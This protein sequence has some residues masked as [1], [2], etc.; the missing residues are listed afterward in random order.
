MGSGT[1]GAR[2]WVGLA[3]ALTLGLSAC[4]GGDEG[5]SEKLDLDSASASPSESPDKPDGPAA[6]PTSFPDIGLEI[7][8]LPKNPKGTK[9]ELLTTWAT[10]EHGHQAMTRSLR[11]NKMLSAT[12]AAQARELMRSQANGLKGSNTHYT[13]ERTVELIDLDLRGRFAVLDACDDTSRSR[14]VKNG[15]KEKEAPG[16]KQLVRMDLTFTGGAW[17]IT[18]IEPGEDRC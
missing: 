18:S 13:G 9:R 4:G 6:I 8:G 2:R 15:V 14:L 1:V 17:R 16:D 12:T 7:T 5:S 3:L 10:F 11:W